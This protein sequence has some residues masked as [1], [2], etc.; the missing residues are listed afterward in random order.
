MW[1]Y[2][3]LGSETSTSLIGRGTATGIL[4]AVLTT[5]LLSVVSD[6]KRE[7]TTRGIIV[8]KRTAKV[9]GS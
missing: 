6:S 8:S 2:R 3:L 4:T 7:A 1:R 9:D 5:V